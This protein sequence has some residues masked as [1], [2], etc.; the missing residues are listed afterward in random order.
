MTKTKGQ[1]HSSGDFW[2]RAVH[3]QIQFRRD[4]SPQGVPGAASHEQRG[5][6][7]VGFNWEA[8]RRI[9]KGSPRATN[10]N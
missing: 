6:G 1:K 5:G 4:L 8:G 7:T 3:V 10:G 2:L 9:K